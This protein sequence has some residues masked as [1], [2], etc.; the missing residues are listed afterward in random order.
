MRDFSEPWRPNL[1]SQDAIDPNEH[2][3]STAF[4]L[5]EEKE[6]FLLNVVQEFLVLL[7]QYRDATM[8]QQKINSRMNMASNVVLHIG[9]MALNQAAAMLAVLTSCAAPLVS[10]AV[11]GRITEAMCGQSTQSAQ[12][13][14]DSHVCRM[15][16]ML[17]ED[18]EAICVFRA[19]LIFIK[20]NDNGQLEVDC[21]QILERHPDLQ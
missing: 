10:Q 6:E 2:A 21:E 7:K 11:A 8:S 19:H 9:N 1:P 15:N 14:L 18:V 3:P 5:S 13:R 4:I 16:V 20:K 17:N 12:E